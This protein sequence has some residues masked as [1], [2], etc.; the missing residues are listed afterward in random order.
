MHAEI[1][2]LQPLRGHPVV[3]RDLSQA[4]AAANRVAVGSGADVTSPVAIQEDR[5]VPEQVN[6]RAF[7]EQADNAMPR[8]SSGLGPDQG[9]PAVSWC[10]SNQH[11]VGPAQMGEM[12]S[13]AAADHPAAHDHHL[14]PARN[15]PAGGT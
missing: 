14:S 6:G 1:T 10:C 15:R 11:H 9:F 5:F 7:D 13:D 12:V 8:R 2:A 4:N 3:V